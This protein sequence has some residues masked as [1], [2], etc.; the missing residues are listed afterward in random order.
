MRS[1]RTSSHTVKSIPL[2]FPESPDETVSL[3]EFARSGVFEIFFVRFTFSSA[4]KNRKLAESPKMIK[5]NYV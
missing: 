1:F 4:Y 5:W 3:R 2:E